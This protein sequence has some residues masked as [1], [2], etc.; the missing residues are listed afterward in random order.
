MINGCRT[1]MTWT[2]GGK[3]RTLKAQW[4]I[5]GARLDIYLPVVLM[6]DGEM[7]GSGRLNF[8]GGRSKW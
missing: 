8:R 4:G 1:G 6:P 7:T 2:L 5:P 3:Q